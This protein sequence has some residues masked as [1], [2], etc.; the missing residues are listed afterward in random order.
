M[1]PDR[2][3][4]PGRIGDDAAKTGGPGPSHSKRVSPTA[5]GLDLEAEPL[6]LL[7]EPPAIGLGDLGAV[8]GRLLPLE[9]R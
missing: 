1:P 4:V 5:E 8:L 3:A 2:V 9:P 6:V 7:G